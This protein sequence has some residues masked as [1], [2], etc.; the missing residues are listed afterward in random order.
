METFLL[1]GSNKPCDK[2]DDSLMSKQ[3][4]TR[5]FYDRSNHIKSYQKLEGQCGP[6]PAFIE[7]QSTILSETLT[8]TTSKFKVRQ[9]YKIYFHY[10]IVTVIKS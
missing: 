9:F 10:H 6:T 5:A 3:D 8:S 1:L 4:K 2:Y 7:L